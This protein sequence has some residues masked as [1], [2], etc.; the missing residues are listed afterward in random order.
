MM[1]T[2]KNLKVGDKVLLRKNLIVDKTYGGFTFQSLM[3]TDKEILVI[4]ISDNVI[5]GK[6][7]DKGLEWWYPKEML[8]MK[9]KQLSKTTQAKKE[10]LFK[11]ALKTNKD[12]KKIAI[13][14]ASP[15]RGRRIE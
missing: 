2:L 3:E 5:R 7:L 8:K 9:P 6:M 12:L 15:V 11:K 13:A 14:L 10:K 4:M 1:K